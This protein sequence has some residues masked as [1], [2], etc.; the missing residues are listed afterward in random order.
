MVH[1]LNQIVY[2]LVTIV[3]IF[4]SVEQFLMFARAIFSWIQPDEGNKL[5][6]FLLYATEPV[7]VPV[8]ALLDRF[9]SIRNM[10]IDISFTVAW[11]LL[12]VVQ[13]LLPNVRA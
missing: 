5:Y 1:G 3:Y 7:I 12:Y 6:S 4:L 8:R 11:L 9:E 2:V 10:P 13:M